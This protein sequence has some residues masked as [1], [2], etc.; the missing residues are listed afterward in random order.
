[1]TEVI[2]RDGTK[3]LPQYD[4]LLETDERSLN[5]PITLGN[6][7][8][9]SMQ[10]LCAKHL[11]QGQEGACVGFGLIHNMISE[12]FLATGLDA[13]YARNRIYKRAQE[14]DPWPGEAYEGTSTLSG[15]KVMKRLG[16]IKSF[17]R[18][19][20]LREFQIAF[21]DGGVVLS[22]PM[23]EGMMRPDRQGFIHPVGDK[24]GG[25][26][27]FAKELDMEDDFAWLHQSWGEDHGIDGDVKITF[28]ALT[29]CF[30]EGGE[31]FL[32]KR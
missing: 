21:L 23:Y 6:R 16:W 27:V 28:N 30:E 3:G 5:F 22:I 9:R 13:Q 8:P 26:C 2:F 19:D 12:P 18:L 15:V 24:V 17:H 32:L 11:N 4:C 29:Y 1:M 14:I 31:G 25:H 7:E 20:T 10:Y